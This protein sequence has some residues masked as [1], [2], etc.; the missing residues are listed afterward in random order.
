MSYSGKVMSAQSA[1]GVYFSLYH[2]CYTSFI[3]VRSEG[4]DQM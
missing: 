3:P 2:Q 1:I 4:A